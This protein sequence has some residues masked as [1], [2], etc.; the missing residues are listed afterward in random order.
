MHIKEFK[1]IHLN[2][3]CFIVGNGPSLNKHN[4]DKIKDDIS[5][6]CN[7]IY[8]KKDFSPTYYTI[9]DRLDVEQFHND[10]NKYKNPK[11]KFIPK[12][13]KQ[14]I[15]GDNI[16]YI[17]FGKAKDKYKFIEK[18]KDYFVW[19]GTVTY[20]MIQLAYY[21]GCNPIY[22]IGMDHD[23]GGRLDYG[24][25]KVIRSETD[26]RHH[27]SKEY[28]N[29]NKLWALPDK[30]LMEYYYSIAKKK[31]EAEGYNIFNATIGGKLEI[32]KRIN[33]NEL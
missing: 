25:G 9:E 8:L 20:L 31:L 17:R 18:D 1:D 16:I 14:S 29:N 28:Y 15:Y 3:R 10:I 6:A 11:F 12:Q 30:P 27:F 23:W 21:M 5:I 7:R 33:Y 4:L 22:L 13:Y 2:K 32:F 26:D 19:G 24:E